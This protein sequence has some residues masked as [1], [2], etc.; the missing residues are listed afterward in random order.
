MK[1]ENKEPVHI[2]KTI[3]VNKMCVVFAYNQG[4]KARKMM[5]ILQTKF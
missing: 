2:K 1:C 3:K 5:E 4:F